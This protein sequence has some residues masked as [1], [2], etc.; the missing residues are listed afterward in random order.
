V[1]DHTVL[2]GEHLARIALRYGFLDWQSV[3]EHPKNAELRSRRPNPNVLLPGD[4]VYIPDIRSK[5]AACSTGRTHI[6]RLAGEHCV[7]I[8]VKDASGK[9]YANAKYQMTIGDEVRGGTTDDKGALYEYVRK[10]TEDA[11]LKLLDLGLGWTLKIGF[12]DPLHDQEQDALIVTGVKARLRNLGF[13]AGEVD[14]N[15]DDDAKEAV[16]RF[17]RSV[18]KRDEPDGDLDAETRNAL[19]QEHGA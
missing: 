18:L 15:L 16:K 1:T 12:L 3:Y 14:S 6:F 5:G 13:Y 7:R 4:K 8:V 9:P 17:Q 11:E 10:S 19:Q 2:Q